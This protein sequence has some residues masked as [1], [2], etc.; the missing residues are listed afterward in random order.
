MK[1]RWLFF[2]MAILLLFGLACGRAG[3]PREDVAEE[4]LP[5]LEIIVVAGSTETYPLVQKLLDEEIRT[6]LGKRLGR[7][8]KVHRIT[9]SSETESLGSDTFWDVLLVD[10]PLFMHSLAEGRRLRLLETSEE[11]SN[12]Y[13]R[14]GGR[15]F[16][17]VLQRRAISGDQP[18]VVVLPQML[19]EAGIDTVEYTPEGVEQLLRSLSSFT[20]TPLLV[21]GIPTK[22]GFSLL[23]GLFNV[24]P[25]RGREFFLD[26]ES[27]VYDKVSERGEAF[28]TYV[29]MLYCAGLLPADFLSL[30]QYSGVDM[31]ANGRAAIALFTD[32]A[33]AMK[34]IEGAKANGREVAIVP[35]PVADGALD[36][37]I[38]RALLAMVSH[39][40]SDPAAVAL[41]QL[42]KEMDD[43]PAEGVPLSQALQV[44]T[45]DL[46]TRRDPAGHVYD[47]VE[48]MRY[49]VSLHQMK[50]QSDTT[51]IEPY[52][53]RIAI[54]DLPLSA[55]S[56]MVSQ[57]T[58][59]P[60]IG[61]TVIDTV[62]LRF[63]RRFQTELSKGLVE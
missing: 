39:E 33:I 60:D 35:L 53:C 19:R 17:Y 28:I 15:Q 47:P 25:E 9:G 12:L 55:F 1:I 7:E 59:E 10:D 14:F 46:F 29:R 50:E 20:N 4:G 62:A 24:A 41:L 38:Y 11:R 3:S 16:A 57:W 61:T 49:N 32:V 13:G 21:H 43:G 63:M 8:L 23:Q 37:D 51:L 2:S 45:I 36:G 44:P 26:G 22:G 34:A 40:S 48:H 42:L 6:Q 18:I 58:I 31:V 5:S 30:S 27:V 54:G 56:E 52:Y